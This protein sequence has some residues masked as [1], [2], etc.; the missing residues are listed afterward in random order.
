M[1]YDLWLMAEIHTA[2]E[3]TIVENIYDSTIYCICMTLRAATVL[4]HLMAVSLGHFPHCCL[5][6]T[7][8][9]PSAVAME[10]DALC[11]PP[12]VWPKGDGPIRLRGLSN[13]LP[14]CSQSDWLG[15][16]SAPMRMQSPTP[17]RGIIRYVTPSPCFC[18]SIRVLI[19]KCHSVLF[20]CTRVFYLYIF[21]LLQISCNVFLL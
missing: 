19:M 20:F 15:P 6:C 14:V 10:R 17:A 18:T 5:P 4:V 9:Q 1:T 2:E 13:S 11:C 8:Q 16:R 7:L 3:Y 21:C 12:P